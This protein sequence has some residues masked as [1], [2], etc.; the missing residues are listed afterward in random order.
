MPQ[1]IIA[2][3]A[4]VSVFVIYLPIYLQRRK[5]WRMADE[6]LK[7][8]GED[9][10]KK[11]L[12]SNAYIRLVGRVLWGLF[13]VSG[14]IFNLRKTVAP[15]FDRLTVSVLVVGLAFIVWGIV[16]FRLQIKN[17]NAIK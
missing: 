7:K 13:L 3:W 10:W 9:E 1:E 6:D 14:F 12:R 2:V 17:L 11:Q 15:G 5:N 8:I 16:G 4:A